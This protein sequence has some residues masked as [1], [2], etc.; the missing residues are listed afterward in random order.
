MR[1]VVPPGEGAVRLCQFGPTDQLPPS[2]L[3][4]TDWAGARPANGA[5]R[6]AAAS[7]TTIRGGAGGSVRP[8]RRPGAGPV[9]ATDYAAAASPPRR[10]RRT[11]P[12]AP[13]APAHSSSTV[14]GSGTGVK[15]SDRVPP[16]AIT[17]GVVDGS[18]VPMTL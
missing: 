11:S 17:V 9:S 4:Q 1:A 6:A 18:K 5:R 16:F 15:V 10:G 7:Q 14:A 12:A 3:F 2:G 8:P 13:A